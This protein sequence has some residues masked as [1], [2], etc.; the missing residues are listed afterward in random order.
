[1]FLEGNFDVNL[2]EGSHNDQ[3][4]PHPLTHAKQITKEFSIYF[5]YA[6]DRIMYAFMHIC[7][8]TVRFGFEIKLEL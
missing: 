5:V 4:I 2:N 6:A 1:L 8:S 3:D 7:T